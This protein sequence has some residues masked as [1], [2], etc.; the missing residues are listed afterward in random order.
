T[1]DREEFF[2]EIVNNKMHLS[3]IGEIVQKY[4]LEILNHFP[5]IG[6]DEFIIMPNHVHGIVNIK[7]VIPHVETQNFASL[8][9]A[10]PIKSQNKFGPQSKNLASIIRGFKIGV[11]KY[12][13]IHKIDFTWQSRFY[14]HIIRNEKSF[15]YIRKYIKENPINWKDDR[16]NSEDLWI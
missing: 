12:A 11:K 13:T 16:N 7:N 3:K 10:K 5:F 14:D 9:Q 4:W 2:G 1:K 8:Q 15:Y 6:L